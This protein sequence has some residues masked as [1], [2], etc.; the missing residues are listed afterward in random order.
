[1][2]RVAADWTLWLLLSLPVDVVLVERALGDTSRW[3]FL[4]GLAALAVAVRYRRRMPHAALAASAVLTVLSVS[5]APAQGYFAYQAGRRMSAAART[6]TIAAVTLAIASLRHGLVDPDGSA[7]FVAF[8][9]LLMGGV[10]PWVVGR[11][12]AV[13]RELHDAGW[14]RAA[15]LELEQEMVAERSRLR[16]RA[17]I[18]QDMHDSLGHELSL[19]ALRAGALELSPDLG[20]GAQ[21]AARSL[22]EDVATAVDRLHDVI[23]LLREEPAAR[24]PI[25]ESVPDLVERARVTGLVV[26]LR[27]DLSG[28]RQDDGGPAE[29]DPGADISS[30]ADFSP[31]ADLAVHRIVQ[32]ALTNATRHAPGSP[33]TVTVMRGAGGVDVQVTNPLPAG[34]STSAPAAPAA[35]AQVMPAA[36]SSSRAPGRAGGSGLAGLEERVRLVGGWLRTSS[37]HGWF[38]LEA[39]VPIGVNGDEARRPRPAEAGETHA[40][41]PADVPDLGSARRRL[42]RGLLV[43]AVIVAVAAATVAGYWVVVTHD[44]TMDAAT[45]ERITVGQ[46]RAG[47]VNVLPGREVSRGW[48][49]RVGGTE[50]PG[51]DCHYYTDG[52]FPGGFATYRLCF[53]DGILVSKNDVRAGAESGPEAMP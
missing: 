38:L 6:I 14:Q 5:F 49:G 22:R 25:H 31:A 47:L 11:Y 33:V 41:R 50:E 19:I 35:P 4:L 9:M 21:R 1:M 29:L 36:S 20:E 2:R 40:I 42:R 53:R 45:Y 27:L 23:D 30:A 18:A 12:I 15:Y 7:W 8:L 26:D 44:A 46:A 39:H 28:G 34:P 17:R 37:S 52:N 10:L 13:R 24:R 16:E 43:A 3:P 48:D 51:Q 32:E